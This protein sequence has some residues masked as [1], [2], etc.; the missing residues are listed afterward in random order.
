MLRAELNHVKNLEEFYNEIRQQQ[1]QA[2]GLHYCAHHDAIAKYLESNDVYKE[3]GT[4]QGGTAAAACKMH[5]KQIILID[6]NMNLFKPNKKHFDKYCFENDIKLE[7][8]ESDSQSINTLKESDVMLI[9]TVHKY[10]HI[11]KELFLH[12]NLT[13][14]YIIAHDTATNPQLHKALEEYCSDQ[15][16]K[17]I[18]RFTK[19]VGYS[20]IGRKK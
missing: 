12:G 2:Q 17:V 20:V 18:E 16:W 8:I 9:D 10:D 15:P 13:R 4:H 6:N 11:K 5:P 1:E 19:N 3:L 7:V 14:K